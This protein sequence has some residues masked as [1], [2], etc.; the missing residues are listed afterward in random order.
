LLVT[1]VVSTQNGRL[2]SSATTKSLLTVG[3]ALYAIGFL[4]VALARTP[5]LLV[6]ALLVIGVGNGL[7]TPT[8]FAGLSVMAPDH[9]RGGVM[10]LQTTT[11]GI[12][13]AV[14]P[15]VFTLAGGAIGYQATLLGGSTGAALGAAVL[16]VVITRS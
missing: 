4:G 1:A 7:I 11:I 5:P 15:A 16:G 13:Q 8:L 12:S 2:A 3:F 6:G 14:G 9:V 10:S